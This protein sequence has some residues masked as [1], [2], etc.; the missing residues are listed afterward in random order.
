M[1]SFGAIVNGYC[2]SFDLKWL[3]E[4]CICRQISVDVLIRFSL[5]PASN[6]MMLNLFRIIDHLQ[7]TLVKL[8][9]LDDWG[10]PD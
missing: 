8:Y 6:E 10:R 5:N 9:T 1:D 4:S 2:N 3:K 7:I